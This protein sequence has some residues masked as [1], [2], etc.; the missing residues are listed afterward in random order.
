MDHPI[1]F[2]SRKLSE[3]EQ[4][5][6]TIE[7]DGLTMVYALQKF[8]NYLLG[9]H[10]KMFTY[11]SYLK[12]LINKIVLGGEFVDGYCCSRNLTSK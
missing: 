12:C 3:L 11:H 7:R 8:K 1:E 10:F 2:A 5:Y 9:K 4:N 6:N